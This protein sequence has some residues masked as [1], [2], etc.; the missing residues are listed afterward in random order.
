MSH[1]WKANALRLVWEMKDSRGL[2]RILGNFDLLASCSCV[3]TGNKNL[4]L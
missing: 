3:A 2:K 1:K 4:L